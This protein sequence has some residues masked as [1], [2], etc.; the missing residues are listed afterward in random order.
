MNRRTLLAGILLMTFH[1][2][3]NAQTTT[4]V[5]PINM[6][7]PDVAKLAADKKIVL[8]DIRTP[9]EWSETGVAENAHK[10]DMNDPLFLAKLSKIT[11][12]NRTRPIALICR[13]ASRTRVVQSALMQSGF[14]S[15]INVEGGMIGNEADKG[16]IR[17]G[18]PLAK[19]E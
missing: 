19:A 7:S 10:L 4:P 12:G 17:H 18:L 13:T 9:E 16:W 5:Y 11:D 2:T 3:G 8:I 6:S 1:K 14:S 15:V